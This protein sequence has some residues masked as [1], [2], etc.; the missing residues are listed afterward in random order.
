MVKMMED[1]N[2]W[3]IISVIVSIVSLILTILFIQDKAIRISIAAGILLVVISLLFT[4]LSKE[5]N[6]HSQEIQKI[7]EKMDI[8][9]RLNR[10]E[11][12]LAIK[13]DRK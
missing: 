1:S 6:I 7:Q 9:Q 10:V 3:N 8:Y 5:I 13:G 11:A 12:A 2:R 4:L